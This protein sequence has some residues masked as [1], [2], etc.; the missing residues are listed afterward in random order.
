MT[1]EQALVELRSLSGAP[2]SLRERVRALP[3]PR[4]RTWT[5]PRLQMRRLVLVAAPAV[6]AVAF[7][8]AAL[9]GVVAGGGGDRSTSAGGGS[10]AVFE[11]LQ[12]ENATPIWGTSTNPTP[13]L[14][15]EYD[16]AAPVPKAS[17]Q[18]ARRAVGAGALPPSTTRLN[19]YEAWLRI[20]VDHDVISKAAT[21][22][23]E[24]ARSYGGYVVSVD[25]NTPTSRGRASLVLK[26]PVAKVGDATRKL[27]AFGEVKAQRVRIEDLQRQANAQEKAIIGLTARIESL[28]TALTG[29]ISDAERARLRFQLERAKQQLAAITRG[30]QQTLREGRL[31]TISVTYFAPGTAAAAKPDKPG[32]L[33]RTVREAGDFLVREISWLLYALIVAAP[34]ALLALAVVLGARAARRSS[35]R[36]LLEGT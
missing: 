34:I 27:N 6:L 3:E 5:L 29:S 32:R 19:R 33:E 11:R 26:V 8:A 20:E 2:D 1:T 23:M 14:S 9:N 21:R 15:G 25:M 12:R 31:A 22:A 13:A 10:T 4:A 17:A 24:I 30:H 18:G 35:D 28:E 16:A 7:G 36:R